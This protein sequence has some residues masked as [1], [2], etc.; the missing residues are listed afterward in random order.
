VRAPSATTHL[1][2]W[3]AATPSWINCNQAFKNSEKAAS[4]WWDAAQRG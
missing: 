4:G 3:L 2:G 1:L